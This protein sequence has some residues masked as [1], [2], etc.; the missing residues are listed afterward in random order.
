MIVEERTYTFHPGRLQKFLEEY[1]TVRDLQS[2]T[3]GQMVGY[4]TSEFGVQNQTVHLWAY[5]SLEDRDARR[6]ELAAVPEWQAFLGRIL[7]LLDRQENRI[8]KPLA[9]SPLGSPT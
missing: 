1:E 6:S 2:R 3:L 9:F 4:F 5:D 8:L 7:P